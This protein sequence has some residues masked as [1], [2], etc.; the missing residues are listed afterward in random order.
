MQ[1][2]G[3]EF[4][5]YESIRAL[6]LAERAGLNDRHEL[7][8]RIATLLPHDS[9]QTRRRIASKFIQRYLTGDRKLIDPPAAEQAFVRL[10][11]R[12]RHLPAQ[13]ELLY[14]QLSQ[15]DTVVGAIARELFHP[16]FIAGQP[17]AGIG[18]DAFAAQNGGQ[19]LALEPLLTR[20][21]IVHYAKTQWGF[22][23]R[24]TIDRAL[25]VLQGAGLVDR[26][27][28]TELRR[29]P[30][31][32]SLSE[33]DVSLVTFTY[34]FYNEY[35]PQATAQVSTAAGTPAASMTV[36]RAAVANSDFAR[37]LLLAPVQVEERLEAARRHQLL[38]Q[39]D[40]QI[41]L[42]YANLNFL[43]DALLAKAL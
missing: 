13:I 10:V 26:E 2:F 31:A 35:L 33:H 40:G 28:M 22:G 15:V 32:Y 41:R 18:A 39:N 20:P 1:A 3:Q 34:A 11:A 27:R 36:P 7:R 5:P 42:F 21:F 16:V 37:T 8:D 30:D 24:A 43:V 29:H 4:Y 23:N 6:K 14:Y 9:E 12:H 17:P 38:A 19:L 25:R